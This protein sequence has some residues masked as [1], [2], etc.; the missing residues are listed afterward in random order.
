MIKY[1]GY[2]IRK[3]D[4]SERQMGILNESGC[5]VEEVVI[6]PGQMACREIPNGMLVYDVHLPR[7]AEIRSPPELHR[8]KAKRNDRHGFPKKR[9]G[10]ARWT[11]GVQKVEAEWVEGHDL[12]T[13]PTKFTRLGWAE[14]DMAIPVD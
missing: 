5:K 8:N 14:E 7:G 4:L 1:N 13:N 12:L 9:L 2:I 10:K 11:H 3:I 6:A